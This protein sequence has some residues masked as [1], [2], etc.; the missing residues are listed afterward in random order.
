MAAR[1]ERAA[2]QLSHAGDYSR[3][4]EAALAAVATEPLRESAH[5]RVIQIYLQEGNRA[6][7]VRHYRRYER[8]MAEELLGPSPDVKALVGTLVQ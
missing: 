7:A 5:G 4:L 8:L 1:L 3:A 2:E 6:E